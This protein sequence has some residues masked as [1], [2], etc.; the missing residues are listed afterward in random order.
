M[1]DEGLK[2][3]VVQEEGA[4]R[5]ILERAR[6]IAVVGLSGD[7]RRASHD[8]AVY[9]QARGYRIVPVNP[10]EAEVLGERAYPSLLDIPKDVRIDL[11]DLF[12]RSSEVGMHVDE[13]IARGDAFC[14]WM[15]D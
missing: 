3:V 9:L 2:G 14:V 4:L 7:P 15:Q 8:V 6:T 10:H 13:V 12:R 11:V 1:E 5:S